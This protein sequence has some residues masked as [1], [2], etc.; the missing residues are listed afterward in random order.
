MSPSEPIHAIQ[1]DHHVPIPMRDGALLS[2]EVY[3][4]QGEGK[5]PVIVARDCYDPSLPFPVEFGTFF[6]QRGYV[7]VINNTRGTFQSEG[8]FFPMIDDGWG[9]NRDG[10]DTIE[11][12]AQ[13]PWSDGKVGMYGFS[14]TAFTQYLAASTRPP[15]LKACVP[16]FGS[17]AR[18]I[19]F[20][21]GLHRLKEHRAWAMYMALTRLQ[22]ISAG[23]EEQTS[24][25]NLWEQAQK[26]SEDWFKHLPLKD[27][28]PLADLSPWYFEHLSHLPGDPWWRQTDARTMFDQIDVPMLHVG[29]WYDLYLT[30]T[31]DHYL[32]VV[33]QGRS[34]RCRN[35]QRLVVGPWRHEDTATPP[36][37]LDFG[38]DAIIDFKETAL[39]WFGYWLK[40][41]NS[42]VL[43]DPKV[44]LFLMGENR[45]LD[46]EQWP[47]DDVA[48][49]PVYLRQGTGKSE[50]S[51][52]NGGLTFALPSADEQPDNYAYD[53][54][55]PTP[56]S[57]VYQ[58]A[59]EGGLLTYTTEPLHAPL[60]V[61]GP[62]KAVLY[63]SSSAPDTDWV[64]RL[65]DVGP[66]GQSIR[67]CDGVVRARYRTS[68]KHEEFMQPDEVYQFEID[69]TATAQTF[70]A[71]HR[72][73]IHV[74]SSNFPWLDRNLNTGGPFGE[75]AMGQVAINTIFHDAQHP[76]HVVLPIVA[77]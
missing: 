28:P 6:S 54:E 30:G 40:G 57:E 67:V 34:E 11:W 71:G 17:S 38:R 32:G 12:A 74:T 73:R 15:S 75:E 61:I 33:A 43:D 69:M 70:L 62:V 19:V 45:W 22:Y 36:P 31:L 50:Q 29:G 20:Q 2:A 14:Y 48:Y 60:V 44:R 52:N 9:E 41:Q 55:N 10:Y 23:H 27:F 1:V 3:R 16:F 8:L 56:Y 5:W 18:E 65:C 39:R 42:G 53:P 47:P 26:E 35:A 59:L 77:P 21:H 37:P 64:V 13:Q 58:Q 66:D 4:P 76:S 72:I 63:A 25:L 68:L 49:T 46:L 7:Y 51:L 24:E